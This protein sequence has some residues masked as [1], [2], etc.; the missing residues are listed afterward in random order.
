MFA[1][2]ILNFSIYHNL[3][4]YRYLEGISLLFVLAFN[5]LYCQTGKES[6]TK[7]IILK[8]IYLPVTRQQSI[9]TQRIM[10]V[11]DSDDSKDS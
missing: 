2:K 5:F 10:M 11:P 4:C 1:H 8:I 7:H 3:E 6:E 9:Q